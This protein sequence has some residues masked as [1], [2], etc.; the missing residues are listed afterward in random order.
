VGAL[1]LPGPD[2]A[3]EDC[4]PQDSSVG[5]SHGSEG[6]A[7]DIPAVVGSTAAGDRSPTPEVESKVETMVAEE[8]TSSPAADEVADHD[9]AASSSGP[10]ISPSSPQPQVV[11]ASALAGVDDNI[12]NEP[13]AVLGHPLLRALG[14]VSLDEEMGTVYWALN[15]AQDVLRR[16]S[17][18][19]HNKCLRLLLWT[20]IL[21]RRTTSERAMV[22]AR[23]Q[24][25]DAREDLLNQ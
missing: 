20:S 19:I 2:D 3:A 5:A 22:Q 14:D 12:T 25:L 16:E 9:P 17:G 6:P 15:Q 13:E 4:N 10:T 21:K 1:G 24:H 11:A 7:P 18:D 8:A 23:Q